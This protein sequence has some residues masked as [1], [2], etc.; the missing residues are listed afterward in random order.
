MIPRDFETAHAEVIK[1]VQ[2]FEASFGHYKL[3]EYSGASVRKDF[4]D[5]F[6]IALGLD[7]NHEEQRN[8]YAQE[9][10]VEKSFTVAEITPEEIRLIENA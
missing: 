1:L 5:K 2:S 9:V 10:K 6:F 4:I 7:V 3:T 8:P